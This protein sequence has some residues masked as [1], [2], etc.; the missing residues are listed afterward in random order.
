[1]ILPRAAIAQLYTQPHLSPP[2]YNPE[3]KHTNKRTHQSARRVRNLTRSH[4]EDEAQP[5]R[6]ASNLDARRSSGMRR[7]NMYERANSGTNDY[8]VIGWIA[9]HRA[10]DWAGRISETLAR[11]RVKLVT[12]RRPVAVPSRPTGPRVG[13]E[14]VEYACCLY[15][16]CDVMHADEHMACDVYGDGVSGRSL[17]LTMRVFDAKSVTIWISNHAF[18]SPS[19]CLVAL[20]RMEDYTI[21]KLCGF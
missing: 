12:V 13:C 14:D 4:I 9:R 11:G 8:S 21:V 5:A 15:S 17:T 3:N 16:D 20:A 10:V 18:A 19:Q 2:I 1:M 7:V 6:F